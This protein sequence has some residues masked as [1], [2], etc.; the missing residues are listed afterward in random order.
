MDS[1]EQ[2]AVKDWCKQVAIY[3]VDMLVDHGLL[4]KEDLDRAGDRRGRNSRP[5]RYARLPAIRSLIF[6]AFWD[7]ATPTI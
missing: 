3:G 7:D 4:K 6:A 2:Q 5:P 1:P